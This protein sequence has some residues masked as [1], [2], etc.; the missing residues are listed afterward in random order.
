MN[1]N[2]ANEAIG[3]GGRTFGSS[4][5]EC[6]FTDDSVFS[7]I[8]EKR[9]VEDFQSEFALKLD[10]YICGFQ[11]LVVLITLFRKPQ[12]RRSKATHHHC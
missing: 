2:S 4:V 9:K 8:G 7:L 5:D 3:K 6:S 1:I 12:K 11:Y 10:M